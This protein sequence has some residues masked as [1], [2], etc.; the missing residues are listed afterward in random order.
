MLVLKIEDGRFTPMDI[1]GSEFFKLKGTAIFR[2]GKSYGQIVDGCTKYIE[3]LERGKGNVVFYRGRKD[4][5]E[6]FVQ[7]PRALA[8]P[9]SL[10]L[11][12]IGGL[13][14]ISGLIT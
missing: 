12:E 1:P 11:E 2:I 14:W 13:W 4:N 6:I 9:D 7:G 5:E 8:A 10:I 3:Q